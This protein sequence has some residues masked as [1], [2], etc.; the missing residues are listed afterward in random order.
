MNKSLRVEINEIIS[1][2]SDQQLEPVLDYLKQVQEMT[3]N[4][5]ETANLLKKIITED[6]ELLK[7][8]AQ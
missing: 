2:L 7:K 4:Q 3:T 5:V 6:A 1:T 8:L